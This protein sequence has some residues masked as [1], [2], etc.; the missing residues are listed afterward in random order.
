L[1]RALSEAGKLKDPK[2]DQSKPFDED[3][4]CA[5]YG[6]KERVEL[7]MSSDSGKALLGSS[8][9]RGA[10]HLLI[11]HKATYGDRTTISHVTFYYLGKDDFE[12]NLIFHVHIPE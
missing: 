6:W 11:E 2:G 3:E 9:G 10:G 4:E 1:G 8:N 12:V 5:G 7:A